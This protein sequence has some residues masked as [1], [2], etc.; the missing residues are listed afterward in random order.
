[1]VTKSESSDFGHINEEYSFSVGFDKT[2]VSA[3]I[4]DEA[5]SIRGKSA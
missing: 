2:V 1:M 5:L 3:E 4:C